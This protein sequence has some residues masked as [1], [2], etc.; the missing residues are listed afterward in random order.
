MTPAERDR[1]TRLEAMVDADRAATNDRFLAHH[2]RA[3]RL[4]QDYFEWEK[5]LRVIENFSLTTKVNWAWLI[6][7]A[8]AIGAFASTLMGTLAKHFFP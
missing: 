8:S 7:V 4:Q 6:A 1:L 3:N 5:R 2:D